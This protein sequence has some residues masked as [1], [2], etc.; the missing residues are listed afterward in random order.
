M[1]DK[2]EEDEDDATEDVCEGQEGEGDVA[3]VRSEL[4]GDRQR[5]D[6][7]KGNQQTI[8][9]RCVVSQTRRLPPSQTR[10][11]RAVFFDE[12]GD[13]CWDDDDDDEE[14]EEGG[15]TSR[16]HVLQTDCCLFRALSQNVFGDHCMLCLSLS[17]VLHLL[18]LARETESRSEER[19]QK[20]WECP[21]RSLINETT[22]E[23]VGLQLWIGSLVL[24]DLILSPSF[25]TGVL[26][27]DILHSP[28]LTFLELGSG[29]GFTSSAIRMLSLLTS[30]SVDL[31]LTGLLFFSLSLQV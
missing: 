18:R 8:G 25:R 13:L 26:A 2:E 3:L 4:F 28:R 15:K 5:E 30:A 7:E 1:D 14:E 17:S 24:A 10:R 22:L 21:V 29:V 27:P 23:D 9:F 19:R 12:D 6:A 31:F 11:P 16:D 20:G